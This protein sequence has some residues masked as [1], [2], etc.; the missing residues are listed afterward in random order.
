[1]KTSDVLGCNDW[2]EDVLKD[3]GAEFL[4]IAVRHF[5][6]LSYV[7]SVPLMRFPTQHADLHQL[8]YKVA[9]RA[10]ARVDFGVAV[11]D[12]QPSV[13][14]PS[15]DSD[16][17]SDEDSEFGPPPRVTLSTG[18]VVTPDILVGA[19]GYRSIVRRQVFRAAEVEDTGLSLLV[20]VSRRFRFGLE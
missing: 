17:D 8:L 14:T 6:S 4:L 12:I 20:C 1:M 16:E 13:V 7:Y 15:S 10:G 11:T 3:T 2:R 19:D 18:E 9:L 5:S